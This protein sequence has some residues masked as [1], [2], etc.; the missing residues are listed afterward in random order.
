MKRVR[1]TNSRRA[2]VEIP[3]L[4]E[5]TR[6]V[7]WAPYPEP[8]EFNPHNLTDMSLRPIFVSRSSKGSVSSGFTTKTF[9]YI[10]MSCIGCVPPPPRVILDLMVLIID[11]LDE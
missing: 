7:F 4:G 9:V 2:A 11:F 6:A 3:C 1:E 5:L 8:D 10:F